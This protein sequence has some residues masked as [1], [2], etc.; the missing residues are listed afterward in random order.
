[1]LRILLPILCLAVAT[2]AMA[3]NGANW[4]FG[5]DTY[6]ADR[7]VTVTEDTDG[8]LFVAG[9]KLTVTSDIG[10]SAHMAGRVLTLDG[11]VG[12][13][14]YGAGQSI[15]LHGPVAG[16]ATVLGQD[17][18]V[19]EPVSGNLRAA[20][21]TLDLMAPV[22][23][24]AV[25]TG[26]SVTIDGVISGDV[27]LEAASII[28]GDHAQVGG[29]LDIYT[30]N[31]DDV[32]VPASV[33]SASRV[34]VYQTSLDNSFD[35]NYERPSLLS[36]IRSW[37]GGVIL[38]GVLGTILAAVAPN[39]LGG[40]RERALVRP[41]R[42]GFVGLVGLST[43]IG[44]IVF[45]IMTGI[46][47]IL[48]P[49]SLIAAV[50]L[51]FAGYVVGTYALGVW[52]MNM[53]GRTLPRTTGEHALAAFGG[54]ALAALI[55]LIPWIGWLAVMAIFLT[56]AGTLVARMMKLDAVEAY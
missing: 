11:R 29:T 2:P 28:W 10:G 42:T 36:Q 26:E 27:R 5:G 43:L 22:A 32:D 31:P 14:F 49:V 13:N 15:D 56:G 46:G 52:A 7:V 18:S 8:D 39:Y 55:A 40:L 48:I 23:G 37:L 41:F 51:G 35:M 16:N 17:L 20:G 21:Q 45:L 25:L 19:T 1:M 3:E 6:M 44:S 34:N 9:E 4:R 24:S 47:A 12:D 54:A 53:S 50:L 38:T 30:N 33:A